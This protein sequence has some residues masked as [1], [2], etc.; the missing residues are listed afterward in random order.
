VNLWICSLKKAE[1]KEIACTAEQ[2][3]SFIHI[4]RIGQQM[5]VI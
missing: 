3:Y 2:L 5:M 1:L 4:I